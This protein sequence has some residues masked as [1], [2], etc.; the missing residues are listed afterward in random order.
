VQRPEWPQGRPP[1]TAFSADEATRAGGTAGR[2]ELAP[3]L[4]RAFMEAEALSEEEAMAEIS[5]AKQK[6]AAAVEGP[7]CYGLLQPCGV[8]RS[9]VVVDLT[10]SLR[11][12]LLRVG[13]VYTKVYHFP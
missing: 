13:H 2:I 6:V 1:L 12:G 8:E 9:R 3:L 5:G 10:S 4:A 11:S 7:V